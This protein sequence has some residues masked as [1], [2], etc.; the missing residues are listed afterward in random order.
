MMMNVQIKELLHSFDELPQGD[1]RIFAF[2]ISRRTISFDFP[3]LEDDD[4]VYQAEG[5]FLDL[6]REEAAHA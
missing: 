5:L 2:E 1:Q 6:D 3:P 4:L